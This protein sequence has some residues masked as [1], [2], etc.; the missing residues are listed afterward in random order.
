MTLSSAAVLAANTQRAVGWVLAVLVLVGF[1]VYLVLNLRSS[2]A[3]VGSEIEL[4]PNRKPYY[5]DDVLETTR[6]DRSL[7]QALG[8]IAI[9]AVTLPVYWLREPGRLDNATA[10]QD[11]VFTSRGGELFEAQCQRCHGP[12]GVGGV[13]AVT[14]TDS[15]GAFVATVDWTAP[16][17]TSVLTRFSDEELRHILTYGRNGVM[18]AWGREGGGPLTDQQITTLIR[19]MRSIQA[20]DA[21][22]AA[23]VIDGVFDQLSEQGDEAADE[24]AVVEAKAS[25][26]RAIEVIEAAGDDADALNTALSELAAARA[27]LDAALVS[28]LGAERYG[29]L[30][31]ANPA[32]SGQYSCARCHTNGFSFGATSDDSVAALI[33]EWPNLAASGRLTAYVPGGGYFGPNL[34][35]GVTVRKF[36]NA[37][38]HAGFVAEGT[39]DGFRYGSGGEGSGNM[40]GFGP[41]IDD[42][43]ERTYAAIFTEAQLDAIAAYERGL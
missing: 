10:G 5:D 18:P 41:R 39:A 32:S 28:A 2:K 7:I 22:V 17:L 33:D 31:F 9:V 37:S 34:T 40:P 3:E 38:E 23:A 30:L 42:G 11:R 16:A 15:D 13:A 25:F 26:D 19:Y 8:F 35:N 14:L 29:E 36:P 1:V 4:A 27:V 43:A 21:V 24:T 6:L 12:N 20:P